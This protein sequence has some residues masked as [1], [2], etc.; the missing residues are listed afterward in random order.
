MRV[1]ALSSSGAG[2]LAADADAYGLSTGAAVTA[3]EA[4]DGA[5]DA[6]AL[7]LALTD[8]NLG[9]IVL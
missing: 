2:E 8:V 3:G 5:W 9:A 6:A 4:R 7:A 1:G